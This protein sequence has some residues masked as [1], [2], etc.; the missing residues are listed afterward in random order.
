MWRERQE[1]WDDTDAVLADLAGAGKVTAYEESSSD[2]PFAYD[3]L[4]LDDESSWVAR[5]EAPTGPVDRLPPFVE[6]PAPPAD[7]PPTPRDRLP[8]SVERLAPPADQPTSAA[9]PASPVEQDEPARVDAGPPGASSPVGPDEVEAVPIARRRR[10]AARSRPPRP[11]RPTVEATKVPSTD[12]GRNPVVATLTGVALAAVV[13]LCFFAGPPAVL[14]LVAVAV[15]LATA[16]LFNSL[17]LAGYQPADA[18]RA[19]GRAGSDRRR[20]LPRPR[21]HRYRPRAVHH[22]RDGLV[23]RRDHA[24]LAGRQSRR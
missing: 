11:Q 3:F 15:T 4:D 18:A 5:I 17:R 14:A 7:Q 2:D 16:E 21:C 23:P 20:L 12:A 13:L 9:S 22:G 19:A 1:D 24:P 8:P 10:H 6:R